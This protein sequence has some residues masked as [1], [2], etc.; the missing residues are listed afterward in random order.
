MP[1]GRNRR[2]RRAAPDESQVFMQN[3]TSSITSTSSQSVTT[4]IAGETD[5]QAASTTTNSV[6]VLPPAARAT[7]SIANDKSGGPP[8]RSFVPKARQRVVI[9][10]PEGVVVNAAD[11]AAAARESLKS[12]S[13]P[14]ATAPPAARKR[15]KSQPGAK[16]KK[17]TRRKEPRSQASP[18]R[19]NETPPTVLSSTNPSGDD[20]GHL[21]A[22]DRAGVGIP[23]RFKENDVLLGRSLAAQHAQPPMDPSPPGGSGSRSRSSTPEEDD[24]GISGAGAFYALGLYKEGWPDYETFAEAN[25]GYLE[26]SLGRQGIRVWGEI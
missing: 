17:S 10:T 19:L 18:P 14:D 1:G 15:E 22:G 16:S 6:T 4:H 12:T 5:K 3:L 11:L 26:R 23:R 9:K 13:T 21:T 2:Q 20:D 25:P 7:Q 24:F 8:V